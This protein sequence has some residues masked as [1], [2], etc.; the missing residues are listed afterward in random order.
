[1]P[2]SCQVTPGHS[3]S[4]PGMSPC[5]RT[6]RMELLNYNGLIFKKITY[7]LFNS[8]PSFPLPPS[9]PGVRLSVDPWP[10]K[11]FP[12]S[13]YQWPPRGSSGGHWNPS[14]PKSSSSRFPQ[15]QPRSSWALVWSTG[16][17]GPDVSTG[18]HYPAV[19]HRN[20][21]M[22][23]STVL[24]LALALYLEAM[25]F[26]SSWFSYVFLIRTPKKYIE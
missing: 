5:L 23:I 4:I 22:M 9:L 1:M 15:G 25:F 24:S 10:G 20:C 26:W 12:V 11:R 18:T 14:P 7:A 2:T 8:F 13:L 19:E 16:S 21:K 17:P 3:N 6:L